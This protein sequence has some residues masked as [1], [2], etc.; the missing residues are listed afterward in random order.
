MEQKKID[1]RLRKDQETLLRLLEDSLDITKDFR[2]VDSRSKVIAQ[3]VADLKNADER[4][5]KL[6]ETEIEDKKFKL[7]EKYRPLELEEEKEKNRINKEIKFRECD[8]EERKVALDETYRPLELAEEKEKNI[9]DRDI[10]L[11]EYSLNER[12]VVLEEQLRPLELEIEREKLQ[13]EK[14]KLETELKIAQ[15]Q[16]QGGTLKIAAMVALGAAD[17]LTRGLSLWAV[18]KK[19]AVEPIL[20]SGAASVAKD[21]VTRTPL[22][23]RIFNF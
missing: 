3:T 9:A 18:T 14:L 1:E 11:K 13:M 8:I 10:R 6:K 22:L 4:E 7:D 20:T 12:R 21:A 5:L 19:E 17:I 2:W 15:I 23:G 16:S